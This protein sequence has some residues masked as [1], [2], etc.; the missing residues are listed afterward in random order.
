MTHILYILSLNYY[1]I[2]TK[3]ESKKGARMSSIF[4]SLISSDLLNLGNTI[5]NLDPYCVGYH[6][7]IMDNHFVPSLTWGTMFVDAISQATQN[8]LW[9]HLMVDNPASWIAKLQPIKS[10]SEK[11]TPANSRLAKNSI[12]SFHLESTKQPLD[13]IQAIQ[14]KQWRASIAISPETPVT[15]LI[16]YLP[17]IDHILLMS[18]HPG[19]SGQPFIPKTIN[20]I[21]KLQSY[22]AKQNKTQAITIALDG[23]VT[24][25]NFASLVKLGIKDFA[26]A[27]ALFDTLDPVQAL[28]KLQKL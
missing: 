1:L 21:T 15:E 7:D 24:H 13:I 17:F 10:S 22:L 23:G 27:S 28:Q 2:K 4:P 6:I 9:I 12:I 5:K 3:I 14:Q 19:K 26:I 25:A 16:P 8:Q 18:V 11:K 20:K